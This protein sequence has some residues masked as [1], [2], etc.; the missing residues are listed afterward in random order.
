LGFETTKDQDVA[1]RMLRAA[2]GRR[3]LAHA[4]LFEGPDSVGKRLTA[5]T[6]AK[7]VNC[8]ELSDDSCDR[9]VSCRRIGDGKHPDVITVAPVKAGRVI[10]VEILSELIERAVLK[11]YEGKY[12]VAVIVDAERMNASAANKFLK[13]LE[14]PPGNSIFVLV[15]HNPDQLPATITSRCQRVKFHPLTPHTIEALLV[16]ERGLV[17]DRARVISVLAQGQM[18]KAFELADSEKR[19]FVTKLVADLTDRCDPLLVAQAFLGR[20]KAE[21]ERLKESFKSAEPPSETDSEE[22]A[23]RREAYHASLFRKEVLSYL[24]LL[25]AWY[26]DMLVFEGT[27]VND[28][29]WNADL[30]EVVAQQARHFAGSDIEAKLEAVER[31]ETLLESNVKEDRVF[32]D[33]FYSLAES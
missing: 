19:E 29:L 9:C 31:A 27:G 33:L 20:L 25:R 7:A 32:R 28:H 26:R 4:Y 24:D 17:P 5:L 18:G 11:P 2:L 1:V 30:A 22:L 15:S 6:F 8:E 23:E 13:T 12:R 16:R 3:R 10:K 21:R 14:E